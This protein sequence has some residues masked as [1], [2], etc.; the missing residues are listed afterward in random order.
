MINFNEKVGSYPPQI[1]V[2]VEEQCNLML[3]SD[4]NYLI[5]CLGYNNKISPNWNHPLYGTDLEESLN[6]CRK[7]L[8]DSSLSDSYFCIISKEDRVCYSIKKI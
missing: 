5:L 8:R 4:S 7:I 6:F 2:L 3:D 1:S